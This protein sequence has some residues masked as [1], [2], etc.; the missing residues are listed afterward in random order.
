VFD[1]VVLAGG[2]ARRLGG[3]DK[4]AVPLGGRSLL[5]RVLGATAGAATTVVV[6]PVRHTYRAV[7]WVREDPPGGGPVAGLAA[8][9][10]AVTAEVVVLVAGDLPFLDA[11]TV[12]MLVDGVEEV[13]GCLMTDGLKPQW[14]C[15]A[16]RTAALRTSLLGLEA[17]QG[18]PLRAV[19]DPLR[20][21]R[22]TWR[23]QDDGGPP[24]WT[25]IDT[26]EDLTR[27]QDWLRGTA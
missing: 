13:D 16:W 2:S 26:P 21:T 23:A 22:L 17:T 7:R 12:S 18:A 9:L 5:D 11:T 14:L 19:L 3:L 1:A 25:D 24:P 8:G 4:P 6:G 20:A 15:G 27:A 10:G